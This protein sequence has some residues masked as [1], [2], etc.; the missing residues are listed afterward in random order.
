[1]KLK[2]QCKSTIFQ[3]KKTTTT[4][5]LH[6]TSE[7]IILFQKREMVVQKQI[8]REKICSYFPSPEVFD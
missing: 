6:G 7:Q 8:H 5:D 4:D 1:M 3:I 2:Q